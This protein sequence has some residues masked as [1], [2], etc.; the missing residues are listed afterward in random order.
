[1]GLR[2]V[3][4][5]QPK[6]VRRNDKIITHRN[7]Q[8]IGPGRVRWTSEGVSGVASRRLSARLDRSQRDTAG[9]DPVGQRGRMRKTG[10]GGWQLSVAAAVVLAVC[11]PSSAGDWPTL[12]AGLGEASDSTLAFTPGTHTEAGAYRLLDARLEYPASWRVAQAAGTPG[13]SE[14]VRGRKTTAPGIGERAQRAAQQP[15]HQPLVPPVSVQQLP[16][17]KR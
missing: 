4:V 16:A 11:M 5:S 13:E 1:M 7:L 8:R 9:G 10:L 17:R 12:L 14:S 3:N 2:S 6:E 15:G